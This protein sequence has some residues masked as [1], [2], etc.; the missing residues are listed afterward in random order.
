MIVDDE[1]LSRRAM[2][3][4]VDARDDV[5]VLAE[6]DSAVGLEGTLEQADVVF[7][8]IEMPVMTGMDLA[9]SL[10]PRASGAGPPFVIFV[11]AHDEYAVPAFDTD[12]V[13]YLTKPVAPARLA[14][15]LERVHE[16]LDALT[17]LSDRP[18]GGLEPVAAGPP[19]S[20]VARIGAR[21]V[22]IPLAD[23]ALLE[24]DGVY[25]ALHAGG[26]RYLVRR[27]LDELEQ[28]LVP[29]DF[30]RVHRSYLVRR[31]AVAEIRPGRA[32]GL[33]ELVLVSGEVVP[34][35]R[36]RQAAVVRRLRGDP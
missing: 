25:T 28:V 33:R 35:S 22:V 26:R 16:R 23:V 27:P 31:S 5:E 34:V 2:R 19:T 29:A 13:D 4:L 1:P 6:H 3:Q 8:D 18:G 7:L 14:R 17:P 32:G 9:R 21:E 30:L 10:S 36:R 15:A 12:A 20:L 24:A 11:T